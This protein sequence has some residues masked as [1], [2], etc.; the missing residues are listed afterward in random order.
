MP[1][2]DL[3]ADLGEGAGFDAELMTLVTSA[4]VCCGF[5]AGDPVTARQTLSLALQ[6]GV[7]VGAHP[8]FPDRKHFGRRELAW[9]A[10]EVRTH[11]QYQVGALDALARLVGVRVKYLKPHGALYN[12]ACRDPELAKAIVAVALL[13]GLAVVGLPNSEL[14]TAAGRLNVPFF[15]E[16]FA[17]RRYQPDGSLAPRSEAGAFIEDPAEA[18]E[19]VDWL[20]REKAVRTI[21]IHGDNPE[22][23]KFARAV[24]EGLLLRGF[25]LKSFA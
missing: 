10:A 4:N 11:C 7:A 16:G 24:R 3:N 25:K 22:S 18:V 6:H 13:S 21:C 17:D 12:Q 8:G 15:A 1:S 9:S 2:I 23:V 19:Q 5:H 14:A 20:I